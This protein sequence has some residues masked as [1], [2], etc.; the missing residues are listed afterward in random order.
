M[1]V[2]ADIGT[3]CVDLLVWW[4]GP[5]SHV[6]YE[7]DAMG[8][9]E[10]NCRVELRFGDVP[11]TVRLSRDWARPDRY[12]ITGTRGWIRWSVNDANHFDLG[13]GDLSVGTVELHDASTDGFGLGAG[14]VAA[15]FDEAF[16]LQLRRLM[17][18]EGG[19]PR[20][21]SGSDALQSLGIIELCYDERRRMSMPW[22]FPA[23]ERAP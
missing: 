16:A 15:D 6:F 9:V 17:A 18:D 19:G 14:R 3:H 20:Y 21:V 11:A 12:V 2:L 4:F 23:E 7:D 1:G 22:M 10:C 8:G 5:P 13:I